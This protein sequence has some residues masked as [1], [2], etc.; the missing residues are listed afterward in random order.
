MSS[1]RGSRML[2]LIC[3]LVGSIVCLV[4]LGLGVRSIING[5]G[6]VRTQGTVIDLVRQQGLKGRQVPVV[7]YT[8]DGIDYQCKGDAGSSRSKYKL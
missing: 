8:V 1:D 2:G 7:R 3:I 6:T 5:L 4:G